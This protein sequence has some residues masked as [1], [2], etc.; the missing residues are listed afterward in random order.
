MSLV[1]GQQIRNQTFVFNPGNEKPSA[2]EGMRFRVSFWGRTRVILLFS[3]TGRSLVSFLV[4]SSWFDEYHSWNLPSSILGLLL[5]I[6]F[7]WKT[8][9]VDPASVFD[10]RVRS[11][12]TKAKSAHL[13]PD[14]S[15]T[16]NRHSNMPVYRL[17]SSYSI[18]FFM[19]GK[20]T[21]AG[22]KSGDLVGHILFTAHLSTQFLEPRGAAV[23]GQIIIS[24]FDP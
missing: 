4:K 11:L 5:A 6:S 18:P 3:T 16:S 17:Y 21:R 13:K 22:P 19:F 23:I 2:E 9:P 7:S 1:L 8:Q 15:L 20:F 24:T 10:Q 14:Q 12:W